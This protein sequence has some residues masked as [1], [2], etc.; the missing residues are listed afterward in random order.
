MYGIVGYYPES[1]T[2]ESERQRYPHTMLKEI[3]DQPRAVRSTLDSV[4]DISENA[5]LSEALPPPDVLRAADRVLI[6]GSGT[7]FHA[8]VIG[9]YMIERMAGVPVEV[10]YASEFT[11][12]R[13]IIRP[14]TLAIA[15]SQS[16]EAADMVGALRYARQRGAFSVAISNGFHS[17]LV[18]LYVLG[19][20]MGQLQM[21]LTRKEFERRIALLKDLPGHMEHVLSSS[22]EIVPLAELLSNHSQALYAGRGINYP[23]ALEGALKLKEISSI[24]AEGCPAGE[25]GHGPI[26]LIDS[27]MPV[28]FVAPCDPLYRK[29]FSNIEEARVR[30]GIILAV[31][32][33]RD[34]EID[35][36]SD[37]V[38]RIPST[39]PFLNPL[40]A[41]LPLQLLAYHAAVIRG[42]DMGNLQSLPKCVTVD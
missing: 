37:Y 23:I 10:E 1:F 34:H 14:R 9:K 15:L 35:V 21:H 18:V 30:G 36:V 28:V 38:M 4:V 20:Y 3:F 41:A 5:Y 6:I 24:H 11:S 16:D 7:S 40:L 39:D 22:D 42:C 13:P 26:A 29:T 27:R 32:S 25:L 19:L 31:A 2:A 17:Q 12:R 8:G 33:E